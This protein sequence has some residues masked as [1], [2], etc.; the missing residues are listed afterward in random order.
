MCSIISHWPSHTCSKKISKKLKKAPLLNLIKSGLK[1]RHTPIPFNYQADKNRVAIARALAVQPEVLLFDEPT[2]ALDPEMV[3][4]VLEVIKKLASTGI[5]MLI[6]THEIKFAEEVSDQ[7]IFMD[8]GMI[9]ETNTP[10]RTFILT[11]KAREQRSS[12]TLFYNPISPNG[13]LKLKVD[14]KISTPPSTS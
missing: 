3:K 14:K 5:S 8:D 13:S 9:V 2:S 7:I 11:Q 12:W 10:K 1:I 6:V 4:E